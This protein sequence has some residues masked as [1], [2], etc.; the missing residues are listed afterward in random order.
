MKTITRDI[1]HSGLAQNLGIA[2]GRHAISPTRKEIETIPACRVCQGDGCEIC[3]GTGLTEV[4][5]DFRGLSLKQV[6]DV[7]GLW[8]TRCLHENPRSE[9]KVISF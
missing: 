9:T 5:C 8:M 2:T 7:P 3:L 6:S 1:T 4:D